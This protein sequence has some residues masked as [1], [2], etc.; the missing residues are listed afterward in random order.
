[1]S[2]Q[3]P[4]SVSC[5]RQS[6][7]SREVENKAGGDFVPARFIDH[8]IMPLEPHLRMFRLSHCS[9]LPVVVIGAENVFTQ[10]RIVRSERV[11]TWN[12]QEHTA[13]GSSKKH[14]L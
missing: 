11:P 14:P 10:F 4:K 9:G 13:C 3:L 12:F 1:M 7:G 5:T 6:R 2:T 8:D